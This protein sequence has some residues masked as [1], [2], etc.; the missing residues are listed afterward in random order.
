M[1]IYSV[2]HSMYL[3]HVFVMFMQLHFNLFDG[4]ADCIM[5]YLNHVFVMFM[6]LHLNLFDGWA[7]IGRAHV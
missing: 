6:Q 3:N 5:Y 7:E 1:L 2:A 4:W